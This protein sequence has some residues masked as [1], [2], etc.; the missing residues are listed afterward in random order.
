VPVGELG[1][2]RH[3]A[4][5]DP[6]LDGAPIHPAHLGDLHRDL[7][8]QPLR[9]QRGVENLGHLQERPALLEPAPGLAVEARVADRHPRL[10]HEAVE[11]LLIV[12]T[13]SNRPTPVEGE[14]PHQ[15]V[16]EQDR[17]R[18]QAADPVRGRPA[19]GLQSR[20]LCDVRDL[21]RP[22]LEGHPA[23]PALTVGDGLGRDVVGHRIRRGAEREGAGGL[24]RHPDA[25]QRHRD[26][27]GRRLRDGPEH[28]VHVER[29]RHDV[30]EAGQAAE[31]RRANAEVLVEAGVLER[32]RDLVRE[33]GE[34]L[35]LTAGERL[36]HGPIHHERAHQVLAD[37]G[38]REDG[39][40]ADLLDPAP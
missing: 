36:A 28:L 9:I 7:A 12:G 24:V 4:A 10:R 38:H 11:E 15:R 40:A 25:R 16:L 31:P 20:V 32:D 30:R 33:G 5:V 8:Q 18:E 27:L 17:H 39:P 23:R 26:E 6:A 22:A 29:G 21:E 1:H 35:D 13:Q 3:H 14:H 34:V 2:E 19:P 37:E